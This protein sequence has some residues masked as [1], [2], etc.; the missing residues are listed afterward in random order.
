MINFNQLRDFY[1]VAKN[2]NFTIAVNKLYITQ[3]AVSTQI[4]LF[5]DYCNLKLFKK[6][7]RKIYLQM[8]GKPFIVTPGKSLNMKEKLKA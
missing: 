5:E 8:K 3:P 1:Q 6:K 7:G 2:L 4:K